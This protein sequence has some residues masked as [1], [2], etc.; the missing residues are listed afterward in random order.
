YRLDATRYLIEDGPGT[1]QYDTP[2]T[3][4]LL[5]DYSKDVQQTKPDAILIA[6]NTVDTATLSTYY[7]DGVM[8]FNFPLASAIID[9][10]TSGDATRITS[11][12]REMLNDYPPDAIDAP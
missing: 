7:G 3:H 6:E 1:G 12:L 2:E 8:N 9:S 10:V 11:T 4:Q 5:K